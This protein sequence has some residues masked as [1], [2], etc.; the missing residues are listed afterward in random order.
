MAL[1]VFPEK[2]LNHWQTNAANTAHYDAI[3]R[4]AVDGLTDEDWKDLKK[5]FNKWHLEKLLEA[6]L[7]RLLACLEVR[8][9]AHALQSE[10]VQSTAK[11]IALEKPDGKA[12]QKAYLVELDTF[13][14][15]QGHALNYSDRFN[16]L[17]RLFWENFR[18]AYSRAQAIEDGLREI[19]DLPETEVKLPDKATY[20]IL[21]DLTLWAQRASD[22]LDKELERRQLCRAIFRIGN[23]NDGVMTSAA[24]TSALSGNR[25]FKFPLKDEHFSEL[26]TKPLIREVF[27][28]IS[29]STP[30]QW[31][32]KLAISREIGGGSTQGK[33]APLIAACDRIEVARSFALVSELH[34]V[35]PVGDWEFY[36]DPLPVDRTAGADPASIFFHLIVSTVR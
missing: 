9:K 25:I 23:D 3:D 12:W 5:T 10:K 4:D 36:L 32:G 6:C 13:E 29:G 8:E 19:Y 11:A 30:R 2:Y 31:R 20:G 16:F 22:A 33:T 24:F 1:N 18:Q 21:D 7:A 27:V 26:G 15:L 35:S 14:T 34:N 28:Q 17:K